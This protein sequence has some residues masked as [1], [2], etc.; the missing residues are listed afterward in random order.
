MR[1][2]WEPT[3]SGL[4]PPTMREAV[5]QAIGTASMCWE[6]VAGAGEFDSATA[7]WVLHGLMAFLDAD[8]AAAAAEVAKLRGA[9]EV[10]SN[11]RETW[12]QR[13]LEAGWKSTGAVLSARPKRIT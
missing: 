9:F 1:D 12:R 3:G 11:S 2:P 10:A 8:R 7:E 13:A 6:N 4:T 5:G